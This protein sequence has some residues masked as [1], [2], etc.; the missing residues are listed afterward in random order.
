MKSLARS[1]SLSTESRWS[2]S[3]STTSV[4][5]VPQMPSRHDASTLHAGVADRP[6]RR[7]CPAGTVSV[8]PGPVQ[9]QLED[10]TSASAARPAAW[11]R[12]APGGA[13]RRGQSAQYCLDRRQQS[14]GPAAVD[15]GVRLRRAQHRRPGRA[16][17]VSFCGHDGDPVAVLRR[18]RRGRPSMR[19]RGRRRAGS[20][21][22]RPPPPRRSSAGSA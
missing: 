17:P 8:Q 5:Q 14:L 22:R 9:N 10:S 11:P 12:T 1:S 15:Q 20:S 18:A 7:S 19:G 16:C 4:S 6:R 13:R 3:P 2:T 21:P